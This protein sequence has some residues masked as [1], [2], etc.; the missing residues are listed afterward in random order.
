MI[1]NSLKKITAVLAISILLIPSMY[2]SANAR[3]LRANEVSATEKNFSISSDN[4]YM[5]R[6]PQ[7]WQP[8]TDKNGTYRVRVNN[9]KLLRGPKDSDPVSQ[10]RSY[11]LVYRTDN[12]QNSLGRT[13][14]ISKSISRTVT[15]TNSITASLGITIKKI[16]TA[17][18]S[19]THSRAV[20]DTVGTT[21]T[22]T[23]GI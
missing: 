7:P 20:A 19:G 16:F 23:K 2:T 14:S 6:Q 8:Y 17:N 13:I 22:E 9:I 11:G 15:V 21:I 4:I 1:K 12:F 18:I 5:I 3:V 10:Y